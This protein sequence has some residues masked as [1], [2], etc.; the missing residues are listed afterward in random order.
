M[1]KYLIVI[2]IIIFCSCDKNVSIEQPKAIKSK[3][4]LNIIDD[5]VKDIPDQ[6]IE[7][8]FVKDSDMFVYLGFHY[9]YGKK[10]LSIYTTSD[11]PYFGEDIE[12][13]DK[14]DDINTIGIKGYFYLHNGR[15]VVIYD[16]DD[17]GKYF[18]DVSQ[19]IK[20]SIGFI[21]S[22]RGLGY[23]AVSVNYKNYLIKDTNLI[24]KEKYFKTSIK[25][26]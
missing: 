16:K 8:H 18:Y 12:N 20:D 14:I 24:L 21:R 9:M 17:I 6:I 1:K 13:M 10:T 7:E 2:I 3:E 23:E 26:Y 19:L 25:G 11:A 15:K 5:I 4:L 22:D